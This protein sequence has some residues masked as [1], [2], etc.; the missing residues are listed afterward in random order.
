M[1]RRG[2][3]L[4]EMTLGTFSFGLSVRTDFDG[5]DE[6]FDGLLIGGAVADGG[7]DDLVGRPFVLEDGLRDAH[8]RPRFEEPL[9]VMFQ[10]LR[11]RS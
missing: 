7:C 11:A 4:R 2:R 3:T 6:S 9:T 1:V 8:D 5:V 10:N